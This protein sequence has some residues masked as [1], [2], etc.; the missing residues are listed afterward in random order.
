M[1]NNKWYNKYNSQF[2]GIWCAWIKHLPQE[3]WWCNSKQWHLKLQWWIW[4]FNRIEWGCQWFN[5]LLVH[6]EM[7]HIIMHAKIYIWV[8]IWW[9]VLTNQNQLRTI[10]IIEISVLNSLRTSKILKKLKNIVKNIIVLDVRRIAL[11]IWLV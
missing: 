3:W 4:I 5:N 2:K 8:M 10:A 6:W 7:H 1:H 9:N 11:R